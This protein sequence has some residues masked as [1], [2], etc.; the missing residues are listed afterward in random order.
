MNLSIFIL[1]LH[2]NHFVAILVIEKKPECT[3]N[4]SHSKIARNNVVDTAVFMEEIQRYSG[5]IFSNKF[6]NELDCIRY[7]LKANK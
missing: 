3:A 7:I 6:S 1:A 5:F 4:C 2:W